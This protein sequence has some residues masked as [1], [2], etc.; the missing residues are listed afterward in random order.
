MNSSRTTLTFGCP[1][2]CID[3]FSN[4]SETITLLQQYHQPVC[5]HCSDTFER[6]LDNCRPPS[7]H[8]PLY[9]VDQSLLVVQVSCH[10]FFFY[11]NLKTKYQFWQTVCIRPIISTSSVK[12]DVRMAVTGI[13]LM[14]VVDANEAHARKRKG[15][16]FVLPL[17][18]KQR[19]KHKKNRHSFELW[20]QRH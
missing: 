12:I 1:N 15:R 6:Q 4:I 11:N 19:S 17:P 7:Y 13:C 9:E 10:L 20:S 8:L 5:R 2:I 14:T 18:T 16:W 3:N